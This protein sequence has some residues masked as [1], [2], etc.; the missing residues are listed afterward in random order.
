[1]RLAPNNR[2]RANESILYHPHRVAVCLIV[3]VFVDIGIIVNQA[4]ENRIAVTVLSR[5]SNPPIAFAKAYP[6]ASFNEIN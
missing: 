2:I 5:E 3:I 4:A 6:D 1:M